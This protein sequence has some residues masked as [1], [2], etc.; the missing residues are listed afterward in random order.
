MRDHEDSVEIRDSMICPRDQWALSPHLVSNVMILSVYL[1]L[2]QAAP[3][4]S[5]TRAAAYQLQTN[6]W[7]CLRLIHN[8]QDF[9][10]AS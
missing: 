9:I 4:V 7:D 5:T 8:D 10:N 6:S 1:S 2:C 3:A